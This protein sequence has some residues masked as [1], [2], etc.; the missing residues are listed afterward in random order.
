MMRCAL[1]YYMG[2]TQITELLKGY[3]LHSTADNLSTDIT[4]KSASFRR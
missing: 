1:S 3:F 2:V 4:A